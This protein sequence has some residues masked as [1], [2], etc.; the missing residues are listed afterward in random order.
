[1]TTAAYVGPIVRAGD[2]ADAVAEAARLD[3]PDREVTVEDHVA[4][5]RVQC[6]DECIIRRDTVEQTLGRSFEMR[7][8]EINL[9]S[10]AGQIETTSDHIRF[11]M[12]GTQP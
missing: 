2:V 4:Y 12:R 3:N 7:E 6:V 8:L 5:L 10:F 1:M 11:F 9:A